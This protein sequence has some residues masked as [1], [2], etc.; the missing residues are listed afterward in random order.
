MRQTPAIHHLHENASAGF[1]YGIGH[2]PPA[3]NLLRSFNTG[4]AGKARLVT[5][6]NT[7]S[8]TIS[9]MEARCE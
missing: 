2:A 3:G 8:V 4:L 1:V 5:A 7:P 6:G 9:P